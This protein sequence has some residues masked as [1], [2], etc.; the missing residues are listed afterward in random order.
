MKKYS[1]IVILIVF[2]YNVSAQNK[3]LNKFGKGIINIISQDSSFSMK[4]GLRVQTL[5]TGSWNIN[6]TSGIDSGTSNFSIRR[7]R[8]KLDGFVFTPKLEYK[9]EIGLANRDIGKVDDRSGYAPRMVMDA[10]VKWNFYKNFTLWA[11]QTK[12]PGNRERVISSANMQLVDRSILNSEFNIDRDIGFQLRHEFTLG[13]QFLIR[14]IFAFSQ[15]EGRSNIQNNLGGYQYTGR[16]EF[17]PLGAFTKGGDYLGADLSRESKPKLSIG[18]SYDF[19]N[20]AVKDRSNQGSYMTY[21]LDK[22]GDIDGYFKTDISTIFADLMFNYKGF[23]LMSEYAYRDAKQRDFSIMN[24]DSTFST[25]KVRTGSAFNVQAG[26]VFK[27]NWE[28]AARYTQVAPTVK[29]KS[30]YEQYTL[31]LSKYIVGHKLK[32]QADVG[33]MITNGSPDRNLLCRL[34]LDLHF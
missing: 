14:E 29:G 5:Y 17:L 28:I 21:D 22:N 2:T 1:L 6:D 18:I 3:V 34:Q 20:N 10:I 31:G 30:Q 4:L 16:L 24:D 32:V 13:K 9:I 25:A 27:K 19:N 23:S 12:L 8:I 26:Y 15:G 11:G 33:Y 7:A